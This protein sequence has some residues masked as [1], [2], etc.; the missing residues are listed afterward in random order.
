MRN[1][2]L[3]LGLVFMVLAVMYW[4]VPA[5]TL[6]S[7]FPGFEAGSPR[8]HVKHGVVAA[9]VAVLLFVFARYAGRSRVTP[10]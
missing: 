5:G 6:P 3:F 7:F 2:A 10:P 9:V 4:I 8:I 1:A